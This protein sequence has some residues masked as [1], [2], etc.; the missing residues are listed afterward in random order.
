M[1]ERLS[2]RKPEAV[3]RSNQDVHAN[4]MASEEAEEF[5]QSYILNMGWKTKGSINENNPARQALSAD[6]DSGEEDFLEK[7][8]KFE[9]KYNFRFEEEGGSGIASHSRGV[10]DSVRVK[11]SKR[12]RERDLKKDRKENEKKEKMIELQKLKSL[13]KEEIRRRLAEIEKV[14]GNKT[15]EESCV[16]ETDFDPSTYDEEMQCL[17][18]SDY[19]EMEDC[20]Y[21]AVDEEEESA[22]PEGQ[23][24]WY[25]CDSCIRP[26]RVG[27][28][29]Y[30]C[31]DCEEET[32]ICHN[33]KQAGHHASSHK[34]KKF[35]VA[36]E[37]QPPD[38]WQEVL[39]DIKKKRTKE[40][41]S[42][43][44]D[45]VYGMDY[46]DLIAGDVA[47][48]FKYTLVDSDSFGL[49]PEAILLG[50]DKE[51]NSKVSLKQLHPY[52]KAHAFK[53]VRY[54]DGKRRQQI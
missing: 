8:D 37:E 5:L 54:H 9:T 51:L 52:R 2:S 30:E 33:C 10:K 1:E 20:E 27:N 6:S 50:S 28:I 53:R 29:G 3:L 40:I 4:P 11:E 7:V 34:L 14:T 47:C 22:E 25:Y 36:Q 26:I 39:L 18:G 46:E 31:K 38:N 21:E 24:M 13:K 32:T 49:S 12:K 41:A 43:K 23:N 45:E 16:L 17:L 48:R 35:K 15:A 44:L 19:Y 42:G